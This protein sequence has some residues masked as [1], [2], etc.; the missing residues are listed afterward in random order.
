M[1]GMMVEEAVDYSVALQEVVNLVVTEEG[2]VEM[3][4][5]MAEGIHLYNM[6][7]I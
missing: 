2:V 6:R 5:G 1:V 3:A 4:V 7:H